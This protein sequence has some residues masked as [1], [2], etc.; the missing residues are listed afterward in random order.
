MADWLSAIGT[1]AAAIIAAIALA[2]S[3]RAKE[4]AETANDLA[5]TGNS[6]SKSAND[7]AANALEEASTANRIAAEANSIAERALYVAQ[8]DVPYDWVLEIND[9]G[10]ASVLNDCGHAALGA[11]VVLDSGGVVVTE[12][13]PVDLAPFGNIRLDVKDTVEQHFA[14][15]RQEKVVHPYRDGRL[16]FA[17]RDGEPV[18]TEVRAHLR[19]RTE[20]GIP[21]T[22]VVNTVLRHQMTFDGL[23]R[24]RDE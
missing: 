5:D 18:S 13:G 6:L 12:G 9:D 10:V 24:C 17:G 16:V 8:D 2:V 1:G 3:M 4:I 20:Q 14:K 7:T 15:V 21:R 22:D 23:S 19:W 11:T